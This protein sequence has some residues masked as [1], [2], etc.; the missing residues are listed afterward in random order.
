MS[1]EGR[2]W[3]WKLPNTLTPG[4]RLVALT[5]GDFCHKGTDRTWPSLAKICGRAGMARSSVCVALKA[6]QL[7]GYITVEHAAGGGHD[8][9]RY[10]L[11]LGR[12]PMPVA[13]VDNDEIDEPTSPA[14]G[15]ELVQP[16]DQTSPATGPELVQPLDIDQYLTDLDQTPPPDPL[17]DRHAAGLKKARRTRVAKHYAQ[18][19]VTRSKTPIHSFAGFVE[20]KVELALNDP[21]LDTWLDRYPDA[22]DTAVAAWLHGDTH[23]M[24]YQREA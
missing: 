4:E 14:T 18:I 11:T 23:S 2:E 24:Q 10:T 16:L 7:D 13:A 22:G 8:S 21:R 9:S 3:A 12:D 5:L 6:L 1:V 17:P 15:P 20:S 19:A